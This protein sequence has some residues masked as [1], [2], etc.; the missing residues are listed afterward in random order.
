MAD[1]AMKTNSSAILVPRPSAAAATNDIRGIKPPV[2]IP[3]GWAWLWWALAAVLLLSLAA[4]AWRWWRKKQAAVPAVPPIPAHVRAKNKLR[5]ALSLISDPRLFCTLVSDS[6]RVYLEERFDFHAPERTT[7]EF[8]LEL[9]ATR[10][11]APEQKQSLGEFLQSCDL[12]K[13]ARYEPT[14]TELRALYE[15]ALRL[16]DETQHESIHVP[17]SSPPTA[18]PAQAVAES[19][20]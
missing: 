19:S 15:S 20:A 2:E 14:E 8:L 7:D 9:Q 17:P 10:L 18:E 1:R 11:L 3:S 13:F 12:V 6:L 16:I 4:G 5:E